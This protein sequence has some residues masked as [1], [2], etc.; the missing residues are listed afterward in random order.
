M[1]DS[2]QGL[3]RTKT[4]SPLDDMGAYRCKRGDISLSDIAWS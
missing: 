3:C 2:D 1:S 4:T